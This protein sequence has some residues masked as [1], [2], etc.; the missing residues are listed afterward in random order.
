MRNIKVTWPI[1]KSAAD[2]REVPV[3]FIE[4][5][6]YYQILLIDGSL[7][8]ETEVAKLGTAPSGSDQED[9][10]NNY[11]ANANNKLSPIDPDVGGLSFSP[12]Y[13]PDGWR[14]QLREFEFVTSSYDAAD[15]HEKDVNNNDFNFVTVTCYDSA[16]AEITDPADLGTAV[17]TVV[18]WSPTHDFA[19][20]GGYLRQAATPASNLY[21]WVQ[22]LVATGLAAPN[23]FLPVTF[24]EGGVNMFYLNARDRVGMNGTAASV[25]TS[26]DFVR[27]VVRHDAGIEHRIQVNLEIY[28]PVL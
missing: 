23:D 22:T 20:I 1:L 21:V 25:L 10:E 18:D 6:N 19:I 3:Q 4:Y 15:V 2:A 17:K 28:V 26:N 11:K 5:P 13:A 7:S 16:D 24:A 14:Q 12:K 8:L 9:F 27:T